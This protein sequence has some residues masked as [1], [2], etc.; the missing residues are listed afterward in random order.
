ML[1]KQ[2]R[3]YICTNVDCHESNENHL[4]L[5][6]LHSMTNRNWHMCLLVFSPAVQWRM[7]PGGGGLSEDQ[8]QP[9][10]LRQCPTLL[11][12][13]QR[14]HCLAHQPQTSGFR[15]RGVK[16]APATRQGKHTH[17]TTKPRLLE[18]RRVTLSRK[19]SMFVIEKYICHWFVL[20]AVV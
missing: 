5:A 18:P 19:C 11:Q 4:T 14:K 1:L 13:P 7:E 6:G 16:E 8:L 17:D 10:E 12:E 3:N 20:T 15:S 9:G 2:W